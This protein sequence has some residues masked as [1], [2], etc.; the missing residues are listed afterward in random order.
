M[1][2]FGARSFR[3]SGAQLEQIAPRSSVFSLLLFAFRFL[4][5]AFPSLISRR[6]FLLR[7]SIVFQLRAESSSPAVTT[8][9][10]VRTVSLCVTYLPRFRYG[11]VNSVI[12]PADFRK[13]LVLQV[14]KTRLSVFLTVAR[15]SRSRAIYRPS[16]TAFY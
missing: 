3:G 16:V 8:M 9:H 11:P 14:S 10:V 15:G 12:L 5:R 6:S 13:S 1:G 7:S 2:E 4:C